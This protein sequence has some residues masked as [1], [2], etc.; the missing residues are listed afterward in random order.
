MQHT[1]I[2]SGMTIAYK[3]IVF[4]GFILGVLVFPLVHNCTNY[5]SEY[6][7]HTVNIFF[8]TFCVPFV[9]MHELFETPL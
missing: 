1:R 3:S 5:V 9:K 4:A 8:L 2:H 7:S 6:P